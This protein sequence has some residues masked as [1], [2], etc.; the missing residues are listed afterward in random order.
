[1]TKKDYVKVAGVLR[2]VALMHNC[3]GSE[4]DVAAFTDVLERLIMMF[5]QDNPQ[6]DE[7]KFRKAVFNGNSGVR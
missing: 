6:F 3:D 7:T 1:M 2:W 4:D 5:I